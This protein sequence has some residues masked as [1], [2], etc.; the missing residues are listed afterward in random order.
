MVWLEP[1]VEPLLDTQDE[2]LKSVEVDVV[3]AETA[4]EFPYALDRV[5]IGTVGREELQ[6][7]DVAMPAKPRTKRTGMVPSGVVQDDH[8]NAPPASPFQQVYQKRQ[9]ALRVEC[10]GRHRQQP[11]VRRTDGTEHRH[12]LARRRMQQHRI[13]VF[14]RNPHGAARSVLLKM[15]LV[16]EPQVNVLSSGQPPQFFYIPPARR[17]LPARSQD[18]ACACGTRGR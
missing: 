10:G 5:Q 7:Y 13:G 1:Q 8:H 17:G 15:A 18:E 16:F 4:G 2:F 14:G 9:K 6:A 12:L 11:A 3:R